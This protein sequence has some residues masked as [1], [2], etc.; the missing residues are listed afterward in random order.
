M[1]NSDKTHIQQTL[2]RF[3]L[4]H[5]QTLIYLLLVK[6]GDLRIQ[7]I[8][9]LSGIPRSS[10][11]EA[12][13]A[14]FEQGLAEEVVAENHKIIRPYP[15]I[16]LRHGLSDRISELRLMADD[17]QQLEKI[18]APPTPPQAD[19]TVRYYQNRSGAR[20]LLWNTLKTTNTVYVFSAWGRARYVGMNYYEHFVSQS[21]ERGIH[22][23]VLINPTKHALE[24][25]QKYAGSSISRTRVEDIRAIS[26]NQVEITGETF[27]Y[28]NVYAQLYLSMGKITGF[29]VSSHQFVAMQ[30]SIFETLWDTAE[31]VA[32]LL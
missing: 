10:V 25:I 13:A 26:P 1:T 24:S 28:D 30:R 20:Q 18:L 16:S 12:L 21:R 11:Y 2:Q 19:L 15:V 29:E 6:H 9:S 4:S 5:N 31:P 22:E 32:K 14:L 23:R 7:K 8:A 17:L 27:I 3:G